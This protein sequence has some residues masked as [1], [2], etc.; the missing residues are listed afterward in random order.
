MLIH[1]YFLTNNVRRGDLFH[2][3]GLWLFV[4][5]V[6]DLLDYEDS[7]ARSFVSTGVSSF[8]A[9]LGILNLID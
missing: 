9:Y 6:Q 1:F 8:V 2:I 3:L 5:F 4:V 7:R